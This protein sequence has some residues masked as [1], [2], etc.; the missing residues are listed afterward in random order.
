MLTLIFT[1]L[2]VASLKMVQ[3]YRSR[4]RGIIHQLQKRQEYLS[5]VWRQCVHATFDHEESILEK[6]QEGKE[7]HGTIKRMIQCKVGFVAQSR[8]CVP[9]SQGTFAL[10][11]WVVCI[12]LLSCTEIS[13]DVQIGDVQYTVGGWTF[14][15][16]RWNNYDIIYA[17]FKKFDDGKLVDFGAIERLMPHDKLLYLIGRCDHKESTQLLFAKNSAVLGHADELDF[18][19]AQKTDCDYEFVRFRLAMDYVQILAHLHS[20]ITETFVLCNSHS[21]SLLLSQFLITEDLRLVLGAYDNLPA[22]NAGSKNLDAKV[23][24]SQKEL[25]GGFVAPEQ[26]WPYQSSK[27]FNYAQQPGY[28]EKA[29][30]WKIPD[31]TRVLLNKKGDHQTILDLLEVIHRKCKNL[32]PSTRPT[33]TQVLQEYQFVWKTLGFS[34]T[35]A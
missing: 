33:A 9:C 25:K 22:L 14:Y 10:E 17:L 5:E 34:K 7:L 13:D 11:Q 30:I 31:V 24:C 21:L 15:T 28:T 29:D 26:K 16:A 1:F 8:A 23:K 4:E 18:V 19:L 3:H 32:A 35:V 12:P 20:N 6:S 27:V 2:L